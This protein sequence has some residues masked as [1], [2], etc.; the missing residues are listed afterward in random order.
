MSLFFAAFSMRFWMF[1][2]ENSILGELVNTLV[3]INNVYKLTYRLNIIFS[4]NL[5]LQVGWL[6]CMYAE[7]QIP[8]DFAL[9]HSSGHG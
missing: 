5:E 6:V 3:M 2:N 4:I 9:R 8:R 1:F 7:I